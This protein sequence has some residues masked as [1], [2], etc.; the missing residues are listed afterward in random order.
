MRDVEIRWTK[1][2]IISLLFPHVNALCVCGPSSWR[3]NALDFLVVYFFILHYY[4]ICEVLG[5]WKCGI[6]VVLQII[7]FE[8]P[9][10][11]Y[12]YTREGF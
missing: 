8:E 7:G 2:K 5:K 10:N 11:K 9:R 12:V 3:G 1:I 4:I 6:H